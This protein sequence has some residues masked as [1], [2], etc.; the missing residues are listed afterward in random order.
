MVETTGF[1]DKQWLDMT[2]NPISD[3]TRMT[4]R[5][6]RANY[7]NLEIEVTVND[8]KTYTKPWTVKLNQTIKVDTDLLDY[9]CI[10]NEKDVQHFVVK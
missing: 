4:E 10:E 7:G 9:T 2:G 1:R 5:F 6:R 8:P 3:A